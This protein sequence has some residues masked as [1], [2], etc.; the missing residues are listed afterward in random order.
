MEKVYL[1]FNATTPLAPEVLE[2]ITSA[3]KDAWG[4]PSSSYHAGEY[5]C[6][7][8]VGHLDLRFSLCSV[9][10]SDIWISTCLL[11]EW[12]L[13]YVFPK[14][15]N[16]LL[17][18]SMD[19]LKVGDQIVGLFSL[20]RPVGPTLGKYWF[21]EYRDTARFVALGIKLPEILVSSWWI[22]FILIYPPNFL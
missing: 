16:Q 20:L 18:W 2:A 19:L 3:L 5:V 21:H 8:F 6:G 13:S 9:L 4:N 17:G 22:Q 7:W 12:L 10:P 15:E 14:H 11:Q 1:D